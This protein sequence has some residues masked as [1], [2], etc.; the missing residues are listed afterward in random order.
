MEVKE[1][2]GFMRFSSK[3][4]DTSDALT[5]RERRINI[6]VNVRLRIKLQF[7]IVSLDARCLF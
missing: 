4:G 6:H 5:K 1:K 2:E 7:G 3:L